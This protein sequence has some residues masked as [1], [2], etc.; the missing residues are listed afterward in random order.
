MSLP[1]IVRPDAES[2]IESIRE[3]LD[4]QQSGLGNQF[5]S[6]LQQPFE[7][8]EFM[9]RIYGEVWNG[10]RAARI[11]RFRHIVYY[12][13]ESDRVEVLAVMHGSRDAKNWK[14]RLN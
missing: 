11:K 12:I 7:R 8:I 9:P 10:V 14:S 5:A 3:W 6:R 2:D 4:S 13:V 1:L